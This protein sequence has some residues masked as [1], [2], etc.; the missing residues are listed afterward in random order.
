MISFALAQE[1][2]NAGFTQRTNGNAEYFLNDHL[3]IRREDALRMWYG[4]KAREGW[5]L[6]LTKELVY[7][8]TMTELIEACGLPFSLSCSQ[9]NHW[10]ASNGQ[11]G[12]G[13]SVNGE[14]AK[15]AMARLWLL[16]HATI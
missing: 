1:L 2:K 8:P 3:K 5:E 14:F 16:L 13:K 4:D 11:N 7:C 6:D 15:E 10:H 12:A 9:A